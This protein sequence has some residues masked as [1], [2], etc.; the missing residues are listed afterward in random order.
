MFNQNK[1]RKLTAITLSF[2]LTLGIVQMATGEIVAFSQIS[3][4]AV[5]VGGSVEDIVFDES[6]LNID[7]SNKEEFDTDYSNKEI[8]PAPP[9]PAQPRAVA[10]EISIPA[11]GES[12]PSFDV[13]QTF[14][15]V[16]EGYSEGMV[17]NADN[18]NYSAESTEDIAISPVGIIAFWSNNGA[19][20]GIS[21]A[22]G[23]NVGF[24]SQPITVSGEA[25]PT[26]IASV[27]GLDNLKIGEPVNAVVSF[28]ITDGAFL[29][30]I[31]PTS[32]LLFSLPAGL[33]SSAAIRV[34]DTV[35]IVNITGTPT[36]AQ[37]A[38]SILRY[39]F[40]GPS[41]IA[42]VS[43]D[44]PITG[45]LNYSTVAK[46]DGAP[47]SGIPIEDSKTE[48]SITVYPVTNIGSTGQTVEYAI[49]TNDSPVPANGWQSGLTFDNLDSE[50]TYYVFARTAENATYSA[51]ETEISIGI[52]TSAIPTTPIMWIDASANGIQNTLDSTLITLLFSPNSGGLS[53]DDIT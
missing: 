38:G 42:D 23:A 18:T 12:S 6:E 24:L 25:P 5:H 22:S 2:L 40:I 15:P 51:G 45:V 11:T 35:V 9:F 10:E 53:I 17:I 13:N 46:R 47:V 32:F 7:S 14:T 36:T 21:Y 37:N 19:K 31:H 27:E 39:N 20:N 50:T 30:T 41:S 29:S 49:S 34:S 48:N 8:F 1:F 33:S 44:I 28:T 3:T 26:I 16:I 4:Q 52:T 43:E